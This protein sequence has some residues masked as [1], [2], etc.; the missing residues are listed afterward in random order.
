MPFRSFLLLPFLRPPYLQTLLYILHASIKLSWIHFLFSFH[1]FCDLQVLRIFIY[2][3]DLF[4][5]HIKLYPAEINLDRCFLFINL[6]F[7][8]QNLIYFP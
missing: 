8:L 2:F 4:F 5:I 7:I 3:V 1:R 6:S